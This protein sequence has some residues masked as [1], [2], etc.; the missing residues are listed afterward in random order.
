MASNKFILALG[1]LVMV[2]G[3]SSTPDFGYSVRH[4]IQ[5]QTYD[6]AAAVAAPEF[7]GLD[8]DKAAMA[9]KTYRSGKSGEAVSASPVNI[10][11][12]E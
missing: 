3:C 6:L 1:V 2:C 5:T 8:G 7:G 9:L 10:S 12:G 11:V 4:M